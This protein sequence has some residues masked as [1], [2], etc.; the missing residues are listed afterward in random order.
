MSC[1]IRVCKKNRPHPF[2]VIST[3]TECCYLC[4]LQSLAD[5]NVMLLTNSVP[6]P[7]LEGGNGSDRLSPSDI[8]TTSISLAT[9]GM[10]PNSVS[11]PA[12]VSIPVQFQNGGIGPLDLSQQMSDLDLNVHRSS[13]LQSGNSSAAVGMPPRQ[14]GLVEFSPQM[15]RSQGGG[16][17]GSQNYTGTP[18]MYP[19]NYPQ[20][21]LYMGSSN[22]MMASWQYNPSNQGIK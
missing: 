9:G 8:A 20:S 16:F 7:S 22:P 13:P 12:Q 5:G 4:C 3:L 1:W 18:I 10:D 15:N 2:Y 11:I 14:G 21:T 19:E 6:N 17:S